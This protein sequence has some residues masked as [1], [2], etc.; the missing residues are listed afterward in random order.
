MTNKDVALIITELMEVKGVIAVALV[1]LD[2]A[3]VESESTHEV[4]TDNLGAMVATVIGANETLASV[5]GQGNVDV[6]LSEY[7]TGKI[8]MATVDDH[9]LAIISDETSVIGNLRY[10]VKVKMPDIIRAL[11]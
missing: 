8:L 6:L 3:V 5:F 7:V 9:V 11:Q 10:A 2:G 1:S 4:D